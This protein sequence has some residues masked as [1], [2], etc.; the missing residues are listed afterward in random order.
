[1]EH[2]YTYLPYRSD[3]GFDAMQQHVEVSTMRQDVE[4]MR[5]EVQRMGRELAETT[6]RLQAAEARLQRW[7]NWLEYWQPVFDLLWSWVS[8]ARTLTWPRAST[9][10]E[11]DSDLP[12]DRSQSSSRWASRECETLDMT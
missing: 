9:W 1:M 11:R 2:P 4:A 6:S 10:R 12:E 5:V 7:D 3:Q 8:A